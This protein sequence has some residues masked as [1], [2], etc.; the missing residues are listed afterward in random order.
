[1]TRPA[2]K[3]KP[4]G[5][6]WIGDVPA[7]WEVMRLKDVAT[8]NPQTHI[9]LNEN[10]RVSFVP[11]ECLRTGN[12]EKRERLYSEVAAYTPFLEN[13]ILV[14]KVTPCFENKN[15]A[16]AQ[17][18]T[19]KIGFASSEI[20]IFRQKS[21]NSKFLFYLLLSEYIAAIGVS[22]MT[23]TGGLKRVNTNIATCK[24]P[25]PPVETQKK[26]AEFLDEKCAEIDALIAVEEKMIAELKSYKQSVITEAVTRGIPAAANA[27]RPLKDSG[28]PWLGSVPAHWEVKQISRIS[29]VVRG[30]SPR[31]AGDPQ[32]FHGD[33]IPWITVA[34]VT[35]DDGKFI[36]ET[37]T[38][39]T[40]AGMRS[41]RV[42]DSGTLLLSNSG[43]TL[44][45][46]KI[47]KIRGCINDGS[48]AFLNLTESKEFLFYALKS[49]TQEL[50]L[51]M[52][53]SGQPNLNTQIVKS[54]YIPVP[55]RVEQNGIAKYLDKKCLEID[56]AISFKKE[57][58]TTLQN[59]KKSI[60]FEY[61]IG[62][63]GI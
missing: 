29:S 26:I 6:P 61:T 9:L 58:I 53:G 37:E 40:E 55:T 39:L 15:I 4:S 2:R 59:Y 54:M 36:F 33:F 16:I 45:V 13:D 3:M 11:M 51:Q 31:P 57:K 41:S 21:I 25:V 44:G 17:N 35:K 34:E 47:T 12:I 43:A 28:I 10:D 49:R 30:A 22:S 5:I 52:Q 27:S 8:L 18:L 1:M 38:F 42:V 7:D 56:S 46:P 32:Y 20:F 24:V 48:L 14:A 62:K 50:R 23:G 60:I 63:K 19:N